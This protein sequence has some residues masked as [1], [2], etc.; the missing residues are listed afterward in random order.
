[1]KSPTLLNT[2]PLGLLLGEFGQFFIHA[3]EVLAVVVLVLLLALGGRLGD[4]H[5]DTGGTLGGRRVTELSSGCDEDVGDSVVLAEHGNVG[6]NIHG[7]DVG[8]EDDNAVG[9][10]DGGVRGRDG[11]FAEGLDDFLD[12]ALEALVDGG[13]CEKQ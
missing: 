9:D 12:T 4:D 8:G 13:Y 2:N 5:G 11:R 10:R 1:M 3:A 7:R 6:D